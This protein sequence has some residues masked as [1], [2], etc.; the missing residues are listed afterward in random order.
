MSKVFPAQWDSSENGVKNGVHKKNDEMDLFFSVW[1]VYAPYRI[2]KEKVS[3]QLKEDTE[4]LEDGKFI[5]KRKGEIYERPT[6]K[7]LISGNREQYWR[8]W[9]Q[10]SPTWQQDVKGIHFINPA[11]E[12]SLLKDVLKLNIKDHDSILGFV[13]RYGLLG[14]SFKESPQRNIAQMPPVNYGVCD[15]DLLDFQTAISGVQQSY[16]LWKEGDRDHLLG[17]LRINLAGIREYPQINNEGRIVPGRAGLTLLDYIWLHFY[18]IVIGQYR[19]CRD[20]GSV[21]EE[22]HGNQKLCPECQLMANKRRVKRYR[23]NKKKEGGN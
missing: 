2:Y 11:N 13:N 1:P 22:I 19:E 8:V 23:E 17:K 16:K 7:W 14:V 10:S 20:C 3:E 4:V 5:V 21:F 6:G 12:R 15:E 18:K 9:Q